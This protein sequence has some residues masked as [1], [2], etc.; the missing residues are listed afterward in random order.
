MVF[1]IRF[2]N[3][4]EINRIIRLGD[5]FPPKATK[6]VALEM[7]G[8]MRREAPVDTGR[9]AGSFQLEGR[10][11][12]Y[13][14]VS[15]VEY[16]GAVLTGT[17]PH[18]IVPRTKQALWWQGAAHPVKRVQHPGTAGNDYVGR[19]WNRTQGRLQEFADA[20]LRESV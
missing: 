1:E 3:Q 20:A 6:M 17:Q 12:G 4:S 7:W 15:G 19:A 8:N 18:I 11:L 13:A 14:I 10:G 5:N 9:L 2:E 16:A